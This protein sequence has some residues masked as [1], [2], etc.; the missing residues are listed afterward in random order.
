MALCADVMVKVPFSFGPREM[1]AGTRITAIVMDTLLL[2]TLSRSVVPQNPD[3]Y[4]GTPKPVHPLWPLL[5]AP[6]P[7]LSVK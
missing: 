4:L 7:L 5:I 3:I 1:G 6:E 2:F